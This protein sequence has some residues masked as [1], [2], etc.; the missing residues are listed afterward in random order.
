[1]MKYTLDNKDNLQENKMKLREYQRRYKEE[2]KIEEK[3]RKRRYNEEKGSIEEGEKQKE[4][5]DLT[6]VVK[7]IVEF[8]KKV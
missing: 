2:H 6:D 4:G 5:E 1:M 3:E 8:L 7:Q